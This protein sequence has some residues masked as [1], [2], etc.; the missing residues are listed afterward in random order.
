MQNTLGPNTTLGYC[1][2]VHAGATFE[3]MRANL[4]W[5]ALPVKQKVSPDA[6]MGVGLWLA[7]DAAAYALDN[8]AVLADLGAWMA[9]HG[10]TVYTLNGFPF[11]NF[12]QPIVKTKVYQPD[13]TT[14]Q[15]YEYTLQLATILAELLPDEAEGSISTL[16]IGWPAL[17]CDGQNDWHAQA[18]RAAGRL[19]DLMHRL[20]R[21]ELDTGKL[22]HIDLEPEPGCCLD[23]A[24]DVVDFFEKYLLNTPD[25]PSVRG[26]LRVCHDVCH[27]AVM[28]EPQQEAIAAYRKAGIGVG[29]VQISSAIR[30]P[31]DEIS[32][33]HRAEAMTHL[34]SFCE[35]RYLHQT[36]IRAADGKVHHFTDLPDAISAS[37][38]AGTPTG[39]WRVH[40]H[41]P[42][43]LDRFGPLY[44]TQDQIGQCLAAIEP[45]DEVHHFEVETYAWSVLPDELKREELAD[46]IADELAWVCGMHGVNAE[47]SNR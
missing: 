31:F 7:H 32:E 46:G 16:P 45:G 17:L 23:T 9:D 42:V 2:N 20:A 40:F 1:T 21:I 13:W 36:S 8:R 26:Y 4:K 38:P 22:I 43:Y 28:F 41:V 24:P 47:S 33:E 44:T 12:H 34:K 11:G 25:E 27:S 37:E 10:L 6:P 19:H 5:H 3:E 35:D 15:R 18:K 14:P 39:E 30:M 29:K